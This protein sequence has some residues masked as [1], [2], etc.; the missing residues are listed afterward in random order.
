MLIWA[1][2]IA[3][4]KISRLLQSILIVQLCIFFRFNIALIFFS[5]SKRE[6]Q[7]S[8]KAAWVANQFTPPYKLK[9]RSGFTLIELLVVLLVVALVGTLA[10]L[11][12]GSGQRDYQLRVMAKHMA[13]SAELA[14]EEA[15][16]SGYDTG[17]KFSRQLNK[18]GEEYFQYDWL[19]NTDKGWKAMKDDV[20]NRGK[21][22]PGYQLTVQLEDLPLHLAPRE[23]APVENN[24]NNLKPD[25]KFFS[26]GE[27]TPAEVTLLDNSS[28][29]QLWKIQW[30]MLGDWELYSGDD[31]L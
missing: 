30:N 27:V 4:S 24:K 26:S 6:A 13:L 10:G 25:M 29:E 1:I 11:S 20:F 16:L 22:P 21:V 18:K 15:Q 17:L 12:I 9:R 7:T 3:T 5:G 31:E 14:L 19:I 28:G 2:G 8:T 23:E